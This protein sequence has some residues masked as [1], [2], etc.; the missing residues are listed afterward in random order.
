MA[1]PRFL[2]WILLF[3]FSGVAVAHED[4]LSQLKFKDQV[5]SYNLK[6]DGSLYEFDVE[7]SGSVSGTKA[8]KV[9][10]VLDKNKKIS[11]IEVI[12]DQ[13]AKRGTRYDY[14]GGM[15]VKAQD[16]GKEDPKQCRWAKD[17]SSKRDLSKTTAKHELL[18]SHKE[19]TKILKDMKDFLINLSKADEVESL[20]RAQGVQTEFHPLAQ[21]NAREDSPAQY[22][23]EDR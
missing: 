4:D 3:G 18:T 20:Y 14:S 17:D 7:I 23:F 21:P 16:K 1:Y 6:P 15:F 2:N 12:E 13:N 9:I 10:V 5:T 8:V 11:S 22:F 19:N